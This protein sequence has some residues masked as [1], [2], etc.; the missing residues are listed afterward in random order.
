MLNKTFEGDGTTFS[1]KNEAENWLTENGYSYGSS[2][3]GCPQGV[4]KGDAYI[5]KWKNMTPKERSRMHGTLE[6]GREGPA[7]LKLK[8]ALVA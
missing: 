1:A 6:A 8:M 3:V 4:V 2:C 5:A 7:V